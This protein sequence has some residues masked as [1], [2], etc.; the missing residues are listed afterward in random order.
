M[1]L[2]EYIERDLKQQWGAA[3]FA[4]AALLRLAPTNPQ[5]VRAGALPPV[6]SEDLELVDK[7]VL[8]GRLLQSA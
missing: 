3:G 2:R 7:L 4:A 6:S 1:L 5:E 8:F